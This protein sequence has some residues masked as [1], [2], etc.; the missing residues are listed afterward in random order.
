MGRVYFSSLEGD[1]GRQLR[2]QGLSLRFIK[3]L[4]LPLIYFPFHGPECMF[5]GMECK[6]HPMEFTFQPLER[7]ICRAEAV[8]ILPQNSRK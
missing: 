6:F 5:Y 4:K 3:T 1:R 8:H 7:S 2:A